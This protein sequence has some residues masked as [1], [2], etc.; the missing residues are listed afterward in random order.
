VVLERLFRN[1]LIPGTVI[2][3]GSWLALLFIR[4][5]DVWQ[6][7]TR[8][9]AANGLPLLLVVLLTVSFYVFTVIATRSLVE[10]IRKKRVQELLQI[11]LFSGAIAFFLVELLNG[12]SY[13]SGNPTETTILGG[14][15]NSVNE[16]AMA[17]Y[18]TL[19]WAIF[20]KISL[21]KPTQLKIRLWGLLD[22]LF[23]I[24]LLV[25][26]SR[27]GIW[28]PAELSFLISLS[29]IILTVV[30]GS[31]LDWIGYIS[32]REKIRALVYFA[33]L[34]LLSVGY[35][36]FNRNSV[37]PKESGF[38]IRMSRFSQLE[39]LSLFVILY[40]AITCLL[41]LF[42]LPT[43]SIYTQRSRELEA[44]RN[45]SQGIR[46]Q[47]SPGEVLDIL[48][49]SALL[50]SGAD[51]GWIEQTHIGQ[52]VFNQYRNVTKEQITKFSANYALTQQ[53]LALQKPLYLRKL[54]RGAR[55]RTVFPKLRSMVVVPIASK[56]QSLGALYLTRELYD[57]F[58]EDVLS[59]LGMLAEQAAIGI[60]NLGLVGRSLEFERYQKQIQIA[61][62]MQERLLPRT[63]YEIPGAEF[64]VF[65]EGAEEV[66]GD[67]FEV[68]FISA[69]RTRLLIADVSGTG[70]EAAFYMAELKGVTQTL[71]LLNP[72]GVRFINYLNMALSG[73]LPFGMFITAN[74]VELDIANR[75]IMLIRA[76]HTPAL[77]YRAAT[78]KTEYLRPRGMGIGILRNEQFSSTFQP[79]TVSYQAG[80]ILVLF[81]D[82]IVEARNTADELFGYDRLSE[83]VMLY[84]GLSA[85]SLTQIIHETA[86]NF[87][88][89]GKIHDDHTTLVL[90]LN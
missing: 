79:M 76:G 34:L 68:Q 87:S 19:C 3:L 30:I 47:A 11:A 70:T 88:V 16:L 50:C 86:A 40:N 39:L 43:S 35:I 78:Q 67:Y 20:R 56:N 83:T 48:L 24:S 66:G 61:H 65:Y 32:S 62:E 90:K 23:G 74:Y 57:G 33:I 7:G 12:I 75:T 29:L 36:V 73:C 9:P 82:G 72:D 15:N 17:G 22:I 64:S 69:T 49:D 58:E 1:R 6:G 28:F 59:V 51:A 27:L 85:K 26:V 14:L 55:A 42:N 10:Q 60:E 44:I 46:L 81:T 25:L 2:A 45:L 13:L 18:W 52:S 77:L 31:R 89:D 8:K 21:Y 80:D 84:K 4:E 5:W 71:Q 38:F 41:L 63:K 37:F 53:V 54:A